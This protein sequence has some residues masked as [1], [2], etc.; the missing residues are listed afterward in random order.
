MG[1]EPCSGSIVITDVNTGKV[2]A[3][4]TYPSYDNNKMANKV[5]SEYFNTYLTQSKSSPLINRPVQQAIAPGSTFK[6]VSSVAGLEE[7]VINTNTT[8]YDATV[9]IK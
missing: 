4:V 3:M 8:I 7:G 1:F 2:K 6:I 5:D 9:L